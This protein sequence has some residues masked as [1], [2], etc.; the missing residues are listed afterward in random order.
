MTFRNLIDELHY[1]LSCSDK[2]NRRF[3][4]NKLSQETI[5]LINAYGTSRNFKNDF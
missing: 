2:N 4:L 1:L 3:I 5:D